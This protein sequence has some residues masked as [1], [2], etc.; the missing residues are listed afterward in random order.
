MQ[1]QGMVSFLTW[2]LFLCFATRKITPKYHSHGHINCSAPEV[3]LNFRSAAVHLFNHYLQNS[4]C[5]AIYEHSCHPLIHWPQEDVSVIQ[6]CNFQTQFMYA[7]TSLQFLENNPEKNAIGFHELHYNDI[8]MNTMA[9]EIT[10]ITIVYST[11]Y[12]GVDQ[13]KHQSSASLAFVCGIHRWPTNSRHKGPMMQ[14][15]FPFDDVIM[16]RQRWFR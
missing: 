11:T 4:I 2:V 13:R 12:S 14:K 16:I 10:N 5:C 7:P 15:M 6:M 3:I 8:I 1:S 9:S